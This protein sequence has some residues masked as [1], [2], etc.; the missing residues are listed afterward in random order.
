MSGRWCLVLGK[1]GSADLKDGFWLCRATPR[2]HHA[3][4]AMLSL[5]TYI[6]HF[7]RPA[8]LFGIIV[9]YSRCIANNNI[10]YFVC[11]WCDHL[12]VWALIRGSLCKLSVG[13]PS[14]VTCSWPCF[15]ARAH[16]HTYTFCSCSLSP[17]L[18][19]YFLGVHSLF[20]YWLWYKIR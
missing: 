9:I 5:F 6:K 8:L 13:A 14:T 17:F 1:S 19:I 4:F 16:T 18:F 2:S 3:Q 12:H 11:P 10:I 20:I 15:G 7:P